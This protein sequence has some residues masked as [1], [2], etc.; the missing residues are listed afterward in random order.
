MKQ[1]LLFVFF[2]AS[3]QLSAQDYSIFDDGYLHEI[4]INS[5]DPNFWQN[6]EDDYEDFLNFGTEIPYHSATVEVDGNLIE[7]AGVRQKGYS[8]NFF[9][10]TTKK[11]L[12]INFG[13]F[14][15][16]QEYDGV[17]KINLANGQ[18]DPAII[19]DK[20]NYDMMRHHGIPSPR[21]SH[22]KI[23]IQNEYWGIYA[24]I[25]Q[26]DKKYLKRNFADNDGNLWKNKGESELKW[27]GTNPNNY[28]FELQTNIDENDWTKF[29]DFI[30][31]I[32][33]SAIEE[34]ENELED[35]FDL[36]EYLRILAI[37]ILTNNWDSYLQ[38]GR[39]WYLYHEPK[40]DKMHW[41]PWDYNF[42]FDRRPN[43]Y[44]DF[45]IIQTDPNK[46][47]IHRIFQVPEFKTRYLSYVCEILE[48]NFT[49]ERL[50]SKLDA[51]LDLIDDDWNLATNN[52]FTLSDV[53]DAING[54]TWNGNPINNQPVQGFK[55]YIE[56]RTPILENDIVNENYTCTPLAPS[57]NYHDVVINEFMANNG[58]GSPWADQD[59]ENDDWIELYNNTNS[60]INLSNYFLSDSDSFYHKWELPDVAIPAHS[61]LIVWADKDPQQEGLHTKFSLDKDGDEIYLTYLDGTLIDSIEYTEEQNE[62][63]SLSRIPNGTGDFEVAVVTFNSENSTIL[64]TNEN[65]LLGINI[66]PNPAST[67]L[68]INFSNRVASQVIIFDMLGRNI[69]NVSNSNSQLVISVSTFKS[70]V[71]IVKMIGED[72]N[73]SKRIIIE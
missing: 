37:D 13:I 42:A 9:T 10:N 27:F 65:A 8:S 22:V 17:E 53:Q 64:S 66:Y 19:K 45:D 44:G 35:I 33:N 26:I 32:N 40:T 50:E 25:E 72:Y 12:K 29:M 46:V 23:Y 34:F 30:D 55:K 67:N 51:Q 47:L 54:E 4:R 28:S 14:V 69:Y 62:N 15:E 18:G 61:Y 36:D 11:P 68:H 52:F 58:D 24:I 38:H 56:D 21:V 48:V 1:F 73:I 57:I 63:E 2:F 49:D 3:L 60:S 43:G 71:Y 70:G 6:L 39:N 5:D 16:D 41:L 20:I 59:N 31:F 7:N